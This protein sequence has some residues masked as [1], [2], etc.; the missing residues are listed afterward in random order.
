MARGLL[1]NVEPRQRQ[2]EHSHAA[3][4]VRER[5]RG[6]QLIPGRFERSVAQRERLEEIAD[7]EIRRAIGSLACE[8]RFGP[9]AGRGEAIADLG[10]QRAIRFARLANPRAQL[11]AGGDQ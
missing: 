8:L 5:P 11:V 3:Q 6:D 1:P 2:S 4:D 7:F 9:R 10:E